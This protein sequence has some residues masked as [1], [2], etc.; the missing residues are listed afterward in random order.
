MQEYERLYCCRFFYVLFLLC[1]RPCGFCSVL[2]R[3]GRLAECLCLHRP[4]SAPLAKKCSPI[5]LP[6]RGSW[7][8]SG[9]RES[10][11]RPRRCTAGYS[12]KPPKQ[13]VIARVRS[14][15]RGD[16]HE[17]I[18]DQFRK[19]P[20]GERALHDAQLPAAALLLPLNR[21]RLHML[22]LVHL[23]CAAAKKGADAAW[24][25][26]R[27]MSQVTASG[28]QRAIGPLHSLLAAAGRIEGMA[29]RARDDFS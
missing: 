14:S 3:S 13:F 26:R 19:V 6:H 18:G 4:L 15:P 20:F 16:F 9:L 27:T 8:R 11:P 2:V 7:P 1:L 24:F 12:P 25:L 22:R 21:V 10:S 23:L 5:R 29:R 17:L 28:G